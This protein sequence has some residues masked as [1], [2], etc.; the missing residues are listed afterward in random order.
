MICFRAILELTSQSQVQENI[1]KVFKGVVDENAFIAWTFVTLFW[2]LLPNHR[3]WKILIRSLKETIKLTLF[4]FA[5]NQLTSFLIFLSTTHSLSF[6]LE[7]P[8]LLSKASTVLMSVL[9]SDTAFLRID[10]PS[11]HFFK[12]RPITTG[13]SSRLMLL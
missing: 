4:Y 7:L 5:F 1:I 11:W 2:N 8:F 10:E 12:R 3:S 9:T 13:K 6:P